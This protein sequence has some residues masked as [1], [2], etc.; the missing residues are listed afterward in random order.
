MNESFMQKKQRAMEIAG[1][2]DASSPEKILFL[3]PSS[4]FRFLIQVILSAQTTDAQV[5]KIAPALFEA[6]PDAQAL[7]GADIESVKRTIHSTGHYNTKARH[8]IDCAAMLQETYGGQVPSTMEELTA[9]PGVGRKTASCVL[10]EIYNRPVIIVDTH[11]GRVSQR[12]G[13][14]DSANPEIIEKEMKALL[15]DQMQYRFS[16]T[17]NLFGRSRCTAKKPRC[18]DCPL[19]DLC[20]WPE[21][22]LR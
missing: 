11:F 3:N 15:P 7:A 16:M 18:R 22:L 2:L 1:I 17:L 20:T 5:L 8:I 10:G 19:Y 6:Y 4:P 13:L 14:V 9:L 21:K 12:L